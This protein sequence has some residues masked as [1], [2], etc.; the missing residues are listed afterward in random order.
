[1]TEEKTID[2][3]ATPA[4]D[5]VRWFMHHGSTQGRE[6]TVEEV[7]AHMSFEPPWK[8]ENSIER[9][10]EGN[11][12][13]SRQLVDVISDTPYAID[14]F[15]LDGAGRRWK[16]SFK[17]E[18]TA[19]HRI[20]FIDWRADLGPGVIIRQA[21]ASDTAELAAV[22]R[23]APIVTDGVT[24]TYD[25]GDDFL[26][27]TRLMEENV[28]Y[29]VEKD[30]EIVGLYGAASHHVRCDGQDQRAMLYHH[31][32][33]RGDQE[34][35][36]Y[37][38]ALNMTLFDHYAEIYGP[39]WK[40]DAWW[41]YAYIQVSNAAAMRL[42]GPG[43]WSFGPFRVLV[44]CAAVAG[45][46]AG[47]PA[48]PD[49]AAEIVEVMNACHS[50]ELMYM[51]YTVESL[52]ARMQRAPDLY[53]WDNILI[54]DGALIGAWSSGLRVETKNGDDV[55]RSVR[56]SVLDQ[57]FVPG[58]EAEFERLIRSCSARLVE[59]G[60]TE[61]SFLLSKASPGYPLLEGLSSHMDAFDY[62]M[63]RAEPEGAAERGVFVD[64]IYF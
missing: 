44:D 60:M 5:A 53:T 20:T 45:D 18:E 35:R 61:L 32:R 34:K 12:D 29:V 24:Q 58:A 48:T 42:G 9:F 17:V 39:W 47:R 8:P 4:G 41:V 38:S 16:E 31:L 59:Q 49:D 21:T 56:A 23:S 43:S 55:H 10:K 51:P 64:P 14:L 13:E 52:T 28:F 36:G 25:R 33:I 11:W 46:D 27:F 7:A 37:F 6:L 22:E 50:N 40:D 1:V 26:A 3:P 54:G 63:T 62:K 2:I 19:P 15:Y 57:G 30:G